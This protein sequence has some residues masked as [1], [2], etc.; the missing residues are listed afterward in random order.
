MKTNALASAL[1]AAI[2]PLASACAAPTESDEPMPDGEAASIAE[3]LN[4]PQTCSIQTMTG[5]YLTAV[6]GGGRI[7]DVLHTDATRVG[8]WEKFTLIDAG[9]GTPN[10][11]YGIRTA[12]GR[13]LTAVGGGGRITDVIHSDA[14]QIHGW[15]KFTLIALGGGIYAIQTNDGH[16]LTATGGGGKISDAIHSDS[17]HVMGWEKF[18]VSCGLK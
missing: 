17:T 11:R 9:D 1:V 2:L 18:R 6:G 7:W 14:T 3:P 13:Y 10:V 8:G 4:G 5:N 15:E 12:G 16:F